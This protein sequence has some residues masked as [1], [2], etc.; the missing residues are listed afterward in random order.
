[1]AAGA[2]VLAAGL[3]IG[4]VLLVVGLQMGKAAAPAAPVGMSQLSADQKRTCPTCNRVLLPTMATCPFCSP[5]VKHDAGGT[6]QGVSVAAAQAAA[7]APP[8]APAAP[9][10]PGSAFLDILDGS[11][12]GQR[13]SLSQQPTTLGRAPDNMI[14]IKDASVSSHHAR[15][16]FYQGKYFLSDLQSSNGTYV[17]NTR[18][19]QTQLNNQ[20]MIAFGSTRVVIHCG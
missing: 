9:A 1:V 15:F 16:D 11:M 14:C 10:A 17:N 7:G 19:E 3:V 13:V 20:D 18:I 12:Q 8:A 6:D 2:S 5:A 4:A